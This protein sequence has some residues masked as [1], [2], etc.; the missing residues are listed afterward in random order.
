MKYE[1]WR[2]GWSEGLVSTHESLDE[3]NY[4]AECLNIA[5]GKAFRKGRIMFDICHYYVRVVEE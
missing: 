3:A 5:E 1:V 2:K 4:K